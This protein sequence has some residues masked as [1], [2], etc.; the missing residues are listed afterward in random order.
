[1]NRFALLVVLSMLLGCSSEALEPKSPQ[2]ATTGTPEP[3]ASTG[4]P[5]IPEDL[6]LEDGAYQFPGEIVFDGMSWT[7]AKEKAVGSDGRLYI[8]VSPYREDV[9]FFH[10]FPPGHVLKDRKVLMVADHQTQAWKAE[11]PSEATARSGNRIS[12]AFAGDKQN[13]VHRIVNPDGHLLL[14]MTYVNGVLNGPTRGSYSDSGIHWEAWFE[15]GKVV[16]STAWDREGNVCNGRVRYSGG[17]AVVETIVVTSE[18]SSVVDRL[19]DIPQRAATHRHKVSNFVQSI[20]R[21]KSTTLPPLD[22][23]PAF[24]HPLDVLQEQSEIIKKRDTPPTGM[25]QIVSRFAIG[26]W[27]IGPEKAIIPRLR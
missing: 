5:E 14:E 21:E 7:R 3:A 15:D 25:P 20:S 11:G 27:G 19:R 26:R 13:G 24:R 9:L 10:Q 23:L 22:R 17:F 8:Y 16:E 2:D 6:T 12:T 18:G 1:M 4:A